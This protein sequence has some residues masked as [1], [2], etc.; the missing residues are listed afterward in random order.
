MLF[1]PLSAAFA[2]EEPLL[3]CPVSETSGQI[4]SFIHLSTSGSSVGEKDRLVLAQGA[5]PVSPTGSGN[6]LEPVEA[7]PEEL[8][9]VLE[10][11]NRAFFQFNDK[12]YFW[13]LKPAARGYKAVVPE[14]AR[15]GVRNFFYNLAFPIRFVNCLL[16]GKV[17]GAANELG[18]FMVNTVFGIAGFL[19]VIPDDVK[20]HREDLGQT[21]G[22]YGIGPGFYIVWPFLG[23]STVRDSVG[24]VGDAFINPLNYLVS[25]VAYNAAVRAYDTVN[26]TSLRIGEYEALKRAAIDPYVALRNAYHQNRL[27]LIKD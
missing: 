4:Q 24:M 6:D 21:F 15:V 22:T 8:S 12:L 11:L 17:E 3:T 20:S 2:F 23:P 5:V 9:D 7:E 18:M 25:D 1:A 19:D 14:P 27:S 26:E 13:V 16:Q 10:P